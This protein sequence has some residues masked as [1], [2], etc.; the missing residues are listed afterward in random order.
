[1]SV[2]ESYKTV[3]FSPDALMHV[4]I[5]VMTQLRADRTGIDRDASPVVA[6]YRDFLREQ[7]ATGAEA[8]A[9][10]NSPLYREDMHGALQGDMLDTVL[11]ELREQRVAVG[12]NARSGVSNYLARLERLDAA[13]QFLES[14]K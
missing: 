1:M 9:A 7:I 10:L 13:L 4:T 6:S 5:A 2:T 11:S 14:Q 3:T 12:I 8:L